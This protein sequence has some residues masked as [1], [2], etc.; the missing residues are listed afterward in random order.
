MGKSKKKR[1]FDTFAYFLRCNDIYCISAVG[2][3]ASVHY[4]LAQK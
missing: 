4:T 3:V 1:A 2:G